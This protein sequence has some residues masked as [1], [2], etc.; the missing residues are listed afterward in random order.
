MLV[1]KVLPQSPRTPQEAVSGHQ[2][3]KLRATNAVA[4]DL[5]DEDEINSKSPVSIANNPVAKQILSVRTPAAVNQSVQSPQVK[6]NLSIINSQ[7]SSIGPNI[8]ASKYCIIYHIF[9]SLNFNRGFSTTAQGFRVY[10]DFPFYF[11]L[12]RQFEYP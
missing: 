10:F 2:P 9:L 12:F 11:H 1:R 6:S 7:V 3:P 5:T 8:A 4:I